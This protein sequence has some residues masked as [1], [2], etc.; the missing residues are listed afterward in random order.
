MLLP[1]I[2]DDYSDE[3]KDALAIR[4]AASTNLECPACDSY[5]EGLPIVPGTVNRLT[6]RHDDG[7]P[8]TNDNILAL[9]DKHRRS[10]R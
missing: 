8:A 7:C 9:L 6:M 5:V 4:N 2:R 10:A 3:L 1:A